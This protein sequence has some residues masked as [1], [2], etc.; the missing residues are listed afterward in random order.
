[1]KQLHVAPAYGRRYVTT[2][3]AEAD[4]AAGK[5]FEMVNGEYRGKYMSIRDMMRIKEDGYTEVHVFT[6]H[7]FQH[8]TVHVL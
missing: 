4:F 6:D 8:R 3:S 1:M 5:D 7:T 2:E